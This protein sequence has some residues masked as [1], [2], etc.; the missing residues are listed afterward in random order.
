MT[1]LDIYL[2]LALAGASLHGS[3]DA[4]AW[5]TAT[6]T[7][8]AS[9]TAQAT[10]TS[11]ATAT[12]VTEPAPSPTAATA[13]PRPTTTRVIPTATPTRIAAAPLLSR[14]WTSDDGRHILAH[15]VWQNTEAFPVYLFMPDEEAVSA[16]GAVVRRVDN[17]K[18]AGIPL[19]PGAWFCMIQDER[20]ADLPAETALIR[21]ADGG[22]ARMAPLPDDLAPRYMATPAVQIQRDEIER[23]G[24][25]YWHRLRLLRL[26][27]GTGPVYVLSIH[28]DTRGAFQF[29]TTGQYA[30]PSD[31]AK[32][33]TLATIVDL[34]YSKSHTTT[35]R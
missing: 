12:G 4:T 35:F 15:T 33:V 19:Q 5:P 2:P 34:R 16:T 21:P 22:A 6:N 29:C 13:E 25:T 14:S 27:A 24:Q 31:V 10:A 18:R 8:V 26:D 9:M 20:P 17:S 23:D 32:D 7:P 11:A 30:I 28:L 1:L 3:P